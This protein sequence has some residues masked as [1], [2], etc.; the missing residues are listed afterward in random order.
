MLNRYCLYK[1]QF[2]NDERARGSL[3]KA[4][5]VVKLAKR[6]FPCMIAVKHR[7]RKRKQKNYKYFYRKSFISATIGHSFCSVLF[8]FNFLSEPQRLYTKIF[9][10]RFFVLHVIKIVDMRYA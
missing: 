2:M 7:K 9:L 8:L 3:L 4:K 1:K 5:Y 6:Q 10:R